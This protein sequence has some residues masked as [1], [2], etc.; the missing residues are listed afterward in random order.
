MIEIAKCI[1]SGGETYVSVDKLSGVPRFDPV[2]PPG[3]AGERLINANILEFIEGQ[4]DAIR[5]VLDT[6]YEFCLAEADI[7][8]IRK[9]IEKDLLRRSS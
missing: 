3:E 7:E 6:V 4:N 8:E 2:R 9:E 1:D 5:F